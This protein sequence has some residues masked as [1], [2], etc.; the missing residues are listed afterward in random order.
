MPRNTPAGLIDLF[1]RRNARLR[2]HTTLQVSIDNGD[3]L[4]TYYFASAKI[5]FNGVNWTPILKQASEIKT[6]L[7]RVADQSTVELINTDTAIGREFLSLGQAVG[8]AKTEV[9][10]YWLDLESGA[11][12]HDI[13]QTGLLI[14]PPVDENVVAL[15][16]VSEPYANVSVGASRRVALS[17][18]W[19]FRQPTTCGYAGTLLT[20]NFLLNHADGCEGRHG[21]PLKRAKFGGF[22]FLSS[23]SRLKTI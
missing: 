18:Q 11:D 15:S 4:K 5:F 1:A 13:L 19:L 20:C 6:S 17:C 21:T 7:T 12:F 16:S 9:G 14:A 22:A 2:S 3:I 10:R 23:G 8:G